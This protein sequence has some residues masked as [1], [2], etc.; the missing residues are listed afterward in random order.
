MEKAGVRFVT[1]E[2]N[3]SAAS[4]ASDDKGVTAVEYGFVAALI[5]VSLLGAL[6]ETGSGVA[7][8]F[9]FIHAAM[10]DHSSCVAVKGA[11]S[12]CRT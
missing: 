1:R 5:A 11:E 8:A 9:G 2:R 12:E 3:E 7:R 10:P 6:T 4:L